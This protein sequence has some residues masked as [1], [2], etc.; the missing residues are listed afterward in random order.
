MPTITS[1]KPSL[2]KSPADA[3]DPPK[4]SPALCPFKI[5]FASASARLVP[6]IPP[7]KIKALPEL[8]N[9]LLSSRGAPTITSLFPSPL[10]S[11][12]EATDRPKYSLALC[13]LR[14]TLASASARLVPVIPPKKIKALPES[15]VP[16]LS[17]P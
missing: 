7:K 8:V 13:P 5:T 10:K 2:L 16:L 9:P 17:S 15:F 3:T 11:P 6:V 14:I 1:P 12:A 4:R